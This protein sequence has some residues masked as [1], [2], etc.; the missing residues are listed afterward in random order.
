MKN[1]F[2]AV[3]IT[4]LCSCQTQT[5]EQQPITEQEIQIA[6]DL[7]QGSFDD[8]W[9]GVDSTKI[10]NYHTDD[11]IILEQGEIWDND[12]IKEYMRKQLARTERPKRTNRMEYIAI[13]KYGES[14]QIAYY[15]FAEFTQADT[16][17]GEA[18]WLES[19][20]AVS[21]KE[22]WKLKMMHS[23]WAGD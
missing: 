6:K 21:T 22:G 23:T 11:F 1:L 10:S 19:A 17:V 3:S 15:N 2:I 12:R 5:K 16:L 18:K 7:I 13:D 8:L 20:L 9:A 14:I 4:L